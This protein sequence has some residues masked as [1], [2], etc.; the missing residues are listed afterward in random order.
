MLDDEW[1]TAIRA[2]L[3]H[4]RAGGKPHTTI[5]ARRHHLEHLARRTSGGPWS[6]TGEDIVDYASAQ[7]WVQDTR[8]GRRTTLARFYDWAIDEGHTTENPALRLP[9]VSMGPAVA[10]PASEVAYRDAL[11]RAPH[12]ERIML[13]LAGDVGLRRGEIS[14]I[15]LD[16]LTNDGT[17]WALLVHG[18]GNRDRVVPVPQEL[19]DELAAHPYG[20]LFPGDENGHLSARYVGILIADLLPGTYTAHQ[21]RHR[22]ATRLY[23]RTQDILL[24]Q[25]MLGHASV[26]TTQRYVRFDRAVMRSAVQAMADDAPPERETT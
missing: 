20:W 9:K 8:R 3:R 7:D 22:F 25:A 26:G 12:R 23:A 11:A 6:L 1:R 5:A 15:H 4:E 2:F 13:R 16:D 21:L 14:R 19:G 24:V 18:K 10:R 17:G